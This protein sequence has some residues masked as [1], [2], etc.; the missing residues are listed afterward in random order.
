MTTLTLSGWTQPAGTLLSVAP[1]A[2]PFD[3]SDY[4][5]PE[6]SFAALHPLAEAEHVIGWSLGGLLAI[7]AIRAGI[8][9]PKRLTLLA[10]PYQ[11]VSDEAFRGGMDPLT[12]E[13]F[14]ANY[15]SDATRTMQRF[16]ALMGK[17]DREGTRV[18]RELTYHDT[19]TDTHRWL[20]W[21]DWLGATTLRGADLS[22][23]PPTLLVHGTGD[24][25]APF[26][27]AEALKAAIP[28][29]RLERWDDAGHAP[30]LHDRTRLLETIRTHA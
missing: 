12:Y 13:Q 26:A 22:G 1:A 6:A 24:A 2:H 4:A 28:H 14:R 9:R 27:Q 16:A 25:I 23:L 18:A 17:G 11:F 29:A 7:Q 8:L 19:V 10:A 21:L 20:P 5:T 3:Y 15:A 30:H